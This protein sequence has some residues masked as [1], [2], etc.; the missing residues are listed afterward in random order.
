MSSFGNREDDSA[1]CS[2]IRKSKQPQTIRLEE[3]TS[4]DPG[5]YDVI[6][7]AVGNAFD[8]TDGRILAK[9][10]SDRGDGKKARI[11]PFVLLLL[12][13]LRSNMTAS[14]RLLQS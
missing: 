4:A 5:F 2:G 6:N 11:N 12:A 1:Y 3:L 9:V 10:I 8:Q 14:N 7:S 13:L